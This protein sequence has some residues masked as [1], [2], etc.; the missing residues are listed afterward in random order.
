MTIYK[1]DIKMVILD[2]DYTI[3]NHQGGFYSM[4]DYVVPFLNYLK[5][6]NIKISLASY[7]TNAENILNRLNINTF[8]D[9]IEY[10]SWITHNDNKYCML[11]R[12][13]QNSNINPKN[14]LFIDDQ[15]PILKSGNKLGIHTELI[16]NGNINSCL[17]NYFNLDHLE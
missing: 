5:Q 2:L 1:H 9:I 10:E 17:K 15:L 16:S 13:I 11:N 7:N 14:I 12:I 3:I 4:Y 6:N 8:F